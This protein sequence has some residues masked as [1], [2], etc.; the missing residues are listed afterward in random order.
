[1]TNLWNRR[2]WDA[3]VIALAV[4]SAIFGVLFTS[5]DHLRWG[6]SAGFVPVGLLGIGLLT[7]TKWH[8]VA[9]V[10]IIAGCALASIAWWVMYTVALALIIV[11]GGF[12]SSRLGFSGALRRGD[13]QLTADAS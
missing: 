12:Q 5:N 4:N 9:T 6:I 13:A 7:L 1:M 10:M 8:S 3:A 11:I 2:W